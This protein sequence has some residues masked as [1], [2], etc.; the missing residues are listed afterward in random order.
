MAEEP[1][2]PER[3][4]VV[5]IHGNRGSVFTSS[6][7]AIEAEGGR[8][9]TPEEL[10]REAAIERSAAQSTGEV[11]KEAWAVGGPFYTAPRVAAHVVSPEA[12]AQLDAYALG[13]NKG[14][15]MGLGPGVARQAMDAIDPKAGA[16]YAEQMDNLGKAYAKTEL[17]G[18]LIGMYA[19][20]KMASGL[21][22]AGKLLAGPAGLAEMGGAGIEGLVGGALRTE[23]AGLLGAAGRRGVS[24]GYR[25]LVE[26]ALYGATEA[27]G[28]D[29]LHNKAQSAEHL[30][31]SSGLGAVGGA[32]AG[33]GLGALGGAAGRLLSRPKLARALAGTIEGE[34]GKI[35]A[36][37]DD[38][39]AKLSA[40]TTKAD[41]VAERLSTA[42]SRIT[43]AKA[44]ATAAELA[45]RSLG[46]TPSEVRKALERVKGGN[47]EG[48]NAW[49]LDELA[50]GTEGK[51]IV[52]AAFSGGLEGTPKKMVDRFKLKNIETG[53]AIGEAVKGADHMTNI[54]PYLDDG[55]KIVAELRKNPALHDDW[56]LLDK[57]MGDLVDALHAQ[58]ALGEDG[59]VL[60][61]KVYEARSQIENWSYE[62]K[63]QG[64]HSSH[65]AI[66]AWTRDMDDRVIK[67]LADAS[68]DPDYLKR[69]D[70]LKTDY[71]YGML[72]EDLA[73]S[74][75]KRG[76]A[77]QF[78]NF[79]TGVAA[80]G[81]VATG[82]IIPAAM[83][84]GLGYWSKN[85]GLA[86]AAIALKRAADVGAVSATSS[87]VSDWVTRSA[88]GVLEPNFAARPVTASRTGTSAATLARAQSAVT[89]IRKMQADPKRVNDKLADQASTLSAWAPETASEY[90]KV[91]MRA[92][93]ALAESM[94]KAPPSDPLN[95]FSPP[96]LSSSEAA[97]ILRM[98]DYADAP[99]VF[100]KDLEAGRVDAES[101][102]FMERIMPLT[103]YSL[104]EAVIEE[105]AA[106]KAMGKPVSFTQRT[107]VSLVLGAAVD[108]LFRPATIAALQTP[109]EPAEPLSPKANK[110]LTLPKTAGVSQLDRIEQ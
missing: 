89:T 12:Q 82:H 56:R 83:A 61:S 13:V 59:S 106:R 95:P 6:L 71:H 96:R 51:G 107:R 97:K 38:A 48:F 34:T 110:P 102:A 46:A 88:K 100:F 20:A 104:R 92:L 44:H 52:S 25:G 30:F 15:T 67:E 93:G 35:A 79:K 18:E 94:P 49:V 45:T 36:A 57:K 105:V 66:K 1:K 50:R 11:A 21:P 24:L 54:T 91:T 10:T 53:A 109:S 72:A 60:A 37:S 16:A 55:Q 14:V 98:V 27:V 84:A 41:D 68:K 17:G 75:A 8:R 33:F 4:E 39:A 85:H 70:K 5:D 101:I 86:T 65:D 22:G 3:V 103:V 108:P 99:E 43:D 80:L 40:A 23:G 81:G 74:G 47:V 7:P 58:G 87:K 26:G 32:G 73:E 31:A 69:L 9:V 62:L 77:N 63:A 2:P 64:K 42:A 28:E 29:L 78:F 19:G 76:L 90:A